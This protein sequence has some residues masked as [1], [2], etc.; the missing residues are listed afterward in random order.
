MSRYVIFILATLV[1][2]SSTPAVDTLDVKTT[3][4][5]T[6]A[7]QW[8]TFAIESSLDAIYAD[9]SPCIA[10]DGSVWWGIEDGAV[11]YDGTIW[12]KYTASDGLMDGV[13]M[14]IV[15]GEDGTLWF[16][17]SHKGK[18]GVTR[19]DGKTWRIYSE[20]DG[21]VYNR[22]GW[23]NA[24]A[25]DRSGVIWIGTNGGVTRSYVCLLHD[26]RD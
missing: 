7:G 5:T 26:G 19:Y 2:A 11:R 23:S 8:T 20:E 18:S 4:T 13:V 21:L 24:I 1:S 14:S 15:Q 25:Q 12:T 6:V 17:G 10:Q 16:A 22:I 9:R 3:V